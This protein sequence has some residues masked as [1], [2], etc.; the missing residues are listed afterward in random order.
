MAAAPAV[1]ANTCPGYPE[2]EGLP[3][4]VQLISPNTI[5]AFHFLDEVKHPLAEEQRQGVEPERVM[6]WLMPWL[7]PEG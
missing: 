4:M 1:L 3:G 5:P 2:T 6:E 7:H